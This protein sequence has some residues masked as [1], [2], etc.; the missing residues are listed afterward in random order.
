M[1][2]M[3]TCCTFVLLG[4][5]LSSAQLPPIIDREIF[6]GDPEISY[7]QISPDGK[8]MTFLKPFKNV[9]NL[10]IKKR[11]EPFDK[12]K[13]LTADTTRPIYPIYY[14]SRDSKYVLYVQDKGGNENFHLY[15]V[16]PAAPG[17]P[18]PPSR[19]LTP[20]E[21]VRAMII[22]VSKK[23]PDEI[24]VGLNDRD[25]RLHDVY[26][27]N[28]TTGNRT[29]VRKNQENIHVW[30][31][32]LEGKLRLGI[33][34]TS[35]GGT[36]IL[37]LQGDSLIAV[38][39]VNAEEFAYPIRFASDG[40][41]FYLVTDKGDLDKS[42][43]MLFDLKSGTMK[44]IEK[45]P[46]NEADFTEAIFSDVSNELLATVYVGDRRRVY[47]KQPEFKKDFEKMKKQVPDGNIHLYNMT[48]DEQLWLVYINRDV[49]PGSVYLFDR[50]SG[51]MEFLH[52][53]QPGLP[54]EN[55]S[56][57]KAIRYKA[58]DGMPIPAYL[59]LPKGLAPKKLPTII[60]PHGGPWGRDDW[61]YNSL[62]QFLANRGYAVLLPNFRGSLG[63]GKKFLN[64]GNKQ[65]GIGSMQ[66]DITDGVN[67]LIKQGI[68][69]PKKVGIAGISYGGFATLAGLAFTPDLYAAGFDIVGPSN[70]ITLL[71]TIPPH[72]AP[73][74]KMFSLRVGD[75]ENPQE[76]EMLQKQSPLNS[77]KNIKAPLFV[78]QGANDPRVKKAESD[79]IVV[80]L[81]DLGRSVEYICAPD[82]GHGFAGAENR[83]AL[84]VAME[85]FFG[86]YLGGRVQEDVRE[87]IRK[88]LDAITV[89]VKDVVVQ[90]AVAP[91][92]SR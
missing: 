23:T 38:F 32:D 17:S 7:A 39:S 71:N 61:G 30:K 92:S 43:L 64:A 51:K 49:D 48:A 80:A 66:H 6:F 85:K 58:R 54:V 84:N 47:P 70:L 5:S 86:K 37:K 50:K 26:R 89:N 24:I 75:M 79:Q 56:P 87:A 27:I 8:F 78:A 29:L 73:M 62:A 21:K 90:A 33:R 91:D 28:L 69:D 4:F 19:D 42:Q 18:A 10:W 55:L 63:Y 16:D 35:D 1:K 13:L 83:I 65:W 45:D 46:N 68:T 77:A 57:M 74:K 15:A 72:W 3:L 2:F 81:R 40:N 82:E 14:W 41:G 25:P 20:M 59:V 76:K 36:E 44:F 22:D 34:Q 88:K 11:S 12:A 53:S 31:T 52:A 9:K 60:Y 67:Y